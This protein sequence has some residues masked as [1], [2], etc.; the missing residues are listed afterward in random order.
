MLARSL[1]IPC[2]THS[3]DLSLD[4]GSAVTRLGNGEATHAKDAA[5]G[6]HGLPAPAK[7]NSAKGV[8]SAP[9]FQA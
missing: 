8:K 2:H 4:D 7:P 1:A 5:C 3:L 6:K 9:V